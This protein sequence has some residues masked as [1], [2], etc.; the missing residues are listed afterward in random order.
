MDQMEET[1]GSEWGAFLRCWHF[2]ST[3]FVELDM[4]G[5]KSP[6]EAQDRPGEPALISDGL[7]NWPH[8]PS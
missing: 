4:G 8:V 7:Q 6:W 5:S 1:H 3:G 2:H